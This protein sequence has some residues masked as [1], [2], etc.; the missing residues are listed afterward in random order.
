MYQL[1]TSAGEQEARS[2]KQ[3]VGPFARKCCES[4]IDLVAGAGVENLNR[5]PN[6]ASGDFHFSQRRLGRRTGR[7]DEHGH[8]YRA[9]HQFVQQS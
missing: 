6:S 3:R 8:L 7:V 4:R 9:R 2:D 5:Q 1:H